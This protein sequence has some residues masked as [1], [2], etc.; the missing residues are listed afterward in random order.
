M[1]KTLKWNSSKLK[2][3]TFKE[4]FLKEEPSLS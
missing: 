2:L 3:I 4:F 1:L